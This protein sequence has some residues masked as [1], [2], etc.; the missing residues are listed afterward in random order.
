MKVKNI[1]LLSI[2]FT[3]FCSVI[4]STTANASMHNLQETSFEISIEDEIQSET[5]EDEKLFSDISLKSIKDKKITLAVNSS[6]LI[7]DTSQ[8][9]NIFRPPIS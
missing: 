4:V 3:F 2:L 9:N 8:L 6:D 5:L 1:Y 7:P